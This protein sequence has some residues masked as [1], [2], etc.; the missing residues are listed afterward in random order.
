MIYKVDPNAD[1]SNT[2]W[3]ADLQVAPVDV[4]RALGAP[5]RGANAY[6][7]SGVYSFVEG[8]RVFTLYDWKA[9]SLYSEEL[10]SPLSFWNGQSEVR[11]SIGSNCEDAGDFICWLEEVL[12][13]VRPIHGESS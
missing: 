10:P 7:V 5:Q 4:V 13:G 6:K 9:T 11:F 3:V 12:K 2:S 8:L 1:L